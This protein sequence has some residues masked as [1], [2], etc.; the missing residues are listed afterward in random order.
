MATVYLPSG[1]VDATGGVTA[2]AIDAP[3]VRELLLAI[4][5]RFPAVRSQLETVAVAVDGEIYHEAD[6]VEISE[7]SEVHLVPRVS[8]G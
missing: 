6:F 5:D 4:A 3:R 2:V 1:W 8:G 7:T